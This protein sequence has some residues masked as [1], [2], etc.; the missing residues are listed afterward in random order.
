MKPLLISILAILS[1]AGTLTYLKTRPGGS[2]ESPLR[3]PG[4][5]YQE[6]NGHVY[7]GIK[8]EP[9]AEPAPTPWRRS[10]SADDTR[11]ALKW[12]S[13]GRKSLPPIG[14][15]GRSDADA[16]LPEW[17]SDKMG[18]PDIKDVNAHPNRYRNDVLAHPDYYNEFY[19]RWAGASVAAES[20]A[21]AQSPSPEPRVEPEM[22][23]AR[24]TP[25]PAIDA[26][27]T[28]RGA[29]QLAADLQRQREIDAKFVKEA[30]AET[31]RWN[32]NQ[33]WNLAEPDRTPMST[34]EFGTKE[35]PYPAAKQTQAEID[36]YLKR[37]IPPDSFYQTTD[38]E[39]RYYPMVPQP[40][41]TATP[42]DRS[43]PTL[44]PA[45][46]GTVGFVP[47]MPPTPSASPAATPVEPSPKPLVTMRL[48]A[49][50]PT[51]DAK[52]YFDSGKASYDKKLYENAIS[53]F[54]NAI[55]LVPNYVAAY[56]ER[57]IAYYDQGQFDKAISDYNEAIRLDPND[58]TAYN[59]RGIVYDYQG[60]FDKAISDCNKAIRL[61]P[62]DADAYNNRGVVYNHQGEFNKAIS[63]YNKA[64]RL[65]PNDA[66]AYNNRGIVYR[67]QG[68]LD[69]ANDD[70]ARARQLKGG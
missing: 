9:A 14:Y 1:I 49:A 21:P 33:R 43:P 42:E 62:K 45:G 37:Y 48:P 29:A 61:D 24:P 46:P 47:M 44:E 31:E 34:H 40:V 53:D 13:E 32:K 18:R 58:A 12:M 60:Q 65:D 56:I 67:K 26:S 16:D 11:D 19:R 28:P 5:T 38:G 54:S 20:P 59:N 17:D 7:T 57:G 68:K 35:N 8:D 22:R 15:A 10:A 30:Q 64:I 52:G 4:K 39:V 70:F 25:T 66:D 51:M 27:A 63:D 36:A 3:A 55:R 23:R 69:K 41:P 2:Y 6:V 50:T